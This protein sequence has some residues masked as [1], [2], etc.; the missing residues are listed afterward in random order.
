ME[1]A[2]ISDLGF[3]PSLPS[4][5]SQNTI[6]INKFNMFEKHIY[7]VL[8]S[9]MPAVDFAAKREKIRLSLQEAVLSSGIVPPG[10]EVALYGSSMNNFGNDDAGKRNV[11]LSGFF[12]VIFF[13]KI[14][15]DT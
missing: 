4:L 2:R 10:T 15:Y 5:P 7:D 12:G 11:M 3:L 8:P 13:F 14:C 6:D 1:T 9:L